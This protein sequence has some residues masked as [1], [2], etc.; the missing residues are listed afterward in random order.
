[1]PRKRPVEISVEPNEIVLRDRRLEVR[2]PAPLDPET[3][4]AVVRLA[5]V[6]AEVV[7]SNGKRTATLVPDGQLPPGPHTLL[8]G[9]LVSARGE[10]LSGLVEV[11][12]FVTD[13]RAKVSSVH[14]LESMVRLQVGRLE[15]VLLA[16]LLD[17]RKIEHVL[18]HRRQPPA[19]LADEPEI[20]LLLCRFA[21]PPALEPFSKQTDRRNWRAQFVRHARNKI[22]LHFRQPMLL[23]K[24]PISRDEADD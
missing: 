6:P 23:M 1:M 2:A 15:L 4:A 10:R 22:R 3:A 8:V 24:C 17:S 9:E 20:F 14:R 12:F 13:S 21:H 5:S 11:P 18:D 19:L 7:L 16:A